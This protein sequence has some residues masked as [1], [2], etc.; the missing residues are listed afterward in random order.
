M[1]GRGIR[2]R[3]NLAYIYIVPRIRRLTTARHEI[4]LG[5]VTVGS[6]I[7]RRYVKDMFQKD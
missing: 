1:P 4:P 2:F 5:Q 6:K 3:G 7:R